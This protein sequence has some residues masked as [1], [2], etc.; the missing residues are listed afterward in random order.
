M[1]FSLYFLHRKQS[2]FLFCT[3]FK[4]Q[5]QSVNPGFNKINSSRP[6]R[7]LKITHFYRISRFSKLLSSI[8][9]FCYDIFSST[10]LFNIGFVKQR[11][12]PVTNLFS[13]VFYMLSTFLPLL[14]KKQCLVFLFFG[15]FFCLFYLL[16]FFNSES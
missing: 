5:N 8:L 15:F 1:F 13:P 11:I 16:F 12:Y 6:K 10:F 4:K 2:C 14:F 7:K 3:S 9:F